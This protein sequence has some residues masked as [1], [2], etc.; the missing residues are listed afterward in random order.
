MYKTRIVF[1]FLIIII[2]SACAG[3]SENSQPESESTSP[4]VVAEITEVATE[5]SELTETPTTAP[6]PTLEADEWKTLPIV[7]AISDTARVIYQ[8]GLEIGNN[9]N[10][11]SK[12]GDCQ[13]STDFFLVDFDYPD[14]YGLGEEYAEL[15]ST[16]D[17]YQGSFSRQSLAVKDG[18]NVAAVLSPLRADPKKCEMGESPLACEYRSYKPTVALI[19]METNFNQRSADDYGKYLR[20]IVEYTI[21]Q[22]IVPVLAN[23]AGNTEGDSGI[24]AE[25]AKIANEYDIPMWNFWAAAYPLPNHGF[26]IGLDDGFHLS[27]SRNFFD[28]PGNMLNAWPWRNLT[29]LQVLEAV[30][31]G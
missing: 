27:F 26:D 5:A 19:S 3:G 28:K 2:L 30:R 18:F 8:R 14:R 10:A 11:F 9:P 29:A 17:Y 22:G 1:L 23:K 4:V 7:P 20:L 15:Q 21:S 6:R 31:N 25:I 16:I 24:N 13:T 12:V